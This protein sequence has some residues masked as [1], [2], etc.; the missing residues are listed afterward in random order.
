MRKRVPLHTHSSS[1]SPVFPMDLTRGVD[2]RPSHFRFIEDGESW[3]TEQTITV[4]FV[5]VDTG[6]PTYPGKIHC[7]NDWKYR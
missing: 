3:T 1:H 7:G 2:L 4:R 5:E 6:L